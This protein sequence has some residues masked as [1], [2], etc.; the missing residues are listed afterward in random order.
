MGDRRASVA[1]RLN[2]CLCRHAIPFALD[3][4]EL[5]AEWQRR[6][7]DMKG[8]IACRPCALRTSWRCTNREGS[9]VEE[10]I[11]TDRRF[12]AWSDTSPPGTQRGMVLAAPRSGLLQGAEPYL[13]WCAG[14]EDTPPEVAATLGAALD[15]WDAAQRSR[16]TC[17]TTVAHTPLARRRA[18]V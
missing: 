3:V 11:P 1:F 9:F 6:Y 16:V 8:T 17:Q 18:G 15:E 14:H 2:C 5:D 4:F 12:D 13:L 10:H 7:P